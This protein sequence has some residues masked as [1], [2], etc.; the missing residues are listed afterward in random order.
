MEGGLLSNQGVALLFFL[1]PIAAML[2]HALRIASA[3][4]KSPKPSTSTT[5]SHSRAPY[6]SD[7]KRARQGRTQRVDDRKP[8]G[9]QAR[10]CCFRHLSLHRQAYLPPGSLRRRR[11]PSKPK[12]P[13]SA[14]LPSTR[15]IPE[16]GAHWRADA[17][18]DVP[19]TS[20]PNG[21]EYQYAAKDPPVP[22]RLHD[23]S[24]SRNTRSSEE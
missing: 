22:T 15:T 5:G 8:G 6:A 11:G 18:T 1:T 14:P 16:T 20:V 10:L 3:S 23:R 21:K 2:P 19:A 24:R 13:Y 4:G 9:E 7:P 17:A 12:R